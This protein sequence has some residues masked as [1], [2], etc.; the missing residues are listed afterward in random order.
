MT[1]DQSAFGVAA[2]LCASVLATAQEPTSNVKTPGK[3]DAVIVRGCLNGPTLESVETVMTDETGMVSTPLTY[4]L[5]GDKALL[6]RMREDHDGERIEV[7]G[8]LKSALPHD[9]STHGKTIGK[10][11]VTFG[12]GT[13]P[14]QKGSPDL[15]PA[16][17]VLEVK[18]FDGTGAR[19]AR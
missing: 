10:T 15:Q 19:C 8:V 12:I 1:R 3:G 11:K 16:L 7:N 17:P 13:P 2:L 4:Q 5:K 6:K 14:A 9:N 18:S